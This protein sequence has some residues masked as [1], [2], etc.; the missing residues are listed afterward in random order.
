MPCCFCS[1]RVPL[2]STEW[3]RLTFS[4]L[5]PLHSNQPLS[6]NPNNIDKFRRKFFRNAWNRN[7]GLLGEK[8]KC[9]LCAMQ[10]PNPS[11]AIFS[12]LL[13]LTVATSDTDG[14]KRYVRS[15]KVFNLNGKVRAF[16]GLKMNVLV[17][18]KICY[19]NVVRRHAEHYCRYCHPFS[20]FY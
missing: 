19:D 11:L 9:N 17:L 20:I 18:A 14:F 13:I 6:I 4:S 1:T 2:A 15:A 12:E 16:N 5:C 7:P 3:V 8:Q 10:P